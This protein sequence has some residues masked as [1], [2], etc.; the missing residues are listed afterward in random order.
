[1]N[2][3]EVYIMIVEN[4]DSPAAAVSSRDKRGFKYDLPLWESFALNFMSTQNKLMWR[5]VFVISR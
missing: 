5:G 4:A 2:R 3:C 1:M